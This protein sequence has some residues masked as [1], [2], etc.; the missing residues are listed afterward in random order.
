MTERTDLT[1][2]WEED[3][4][5]VEIAS[6]SVGIIIQDLHDSLK[7]N[8]LQAS[9][10]DD[11]LENLDD[12]PLID[13]SG[14][15]NIGLGEEVGI[16]ATMLDSQVAFESR[17][18]VTSSGTI[19][20]GDAGGASLIDAAGSLVTDLVRRGAVVI[21]FTDE[22]I[23]EVL[24]IVGEGQAITRVLRAGT[25]NQYTIGDVYKIWNII[26]CEISGG[27]L[28]GLDELDAEQSPVFPTAFTQIVRARSASATL[29][30]A[31]VGSFW[32]ALLA[33]HVVP[34]TFGQ[35][36]ALNLLTFGRWLALRGG[37][38]K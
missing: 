16:T 32:D 21:N 18:T 5:I 7:S 23:T 6:P 29:T 31:D 38:G 36:V 25:L 33:D 12:L 24:R 26:Q 28:V 3:P 20:T 15:E 30:N 9:E 14:K 10:N 13:S 17:L 11:S 2:F 4:R 19:T 34:D 35:Q 22:S 27:N 8:T 1:T 37:P